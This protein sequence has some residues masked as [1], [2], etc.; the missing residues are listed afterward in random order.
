MKKI[1]TLLLVL[2]LLVP[3]SCADKPFLPLPFEEQL[4]IDIEIIE[5]YLEE[6]EISATKDDSGIYYVIHIPG[7]DTM[8]T[9]EDFIEVTYEGRLLSEAVFD[10]NNQGIEFFLGQLIS[11]WQLMIPL[12]GEGGSMTIY[13]P[14]VYCY[15]SNKVTG[16]PINSNL[17]FD[18]QLLKVNQGD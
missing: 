6:N 11:A 18:I 16:I 1:L 3:F 15:G 17:I 4:E 8:P 14:S 5:D 9:I 2:F 7:N 10:S 12:I 13:A